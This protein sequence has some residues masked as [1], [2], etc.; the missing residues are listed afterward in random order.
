[1]T[2]TSG[3][4]L[5]TTRKNKKAIITNSKVNSA[6]YQLNLLLK[7]HVLS[8]NPTSPPQTPSIPHNSF[9]LPIN[10]PNSHL[11]P[12]QIPKLPDLL[13]KPQLL[14]DL[15]LHSL[16]PKLLNNLQRPN[17]I[18]DPREYRGGHG[19]FAEDAG[20]LVEFPGAFVVELVLFA[21]V[22]LG[23]VAG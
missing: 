17:R 22:D 18:L 16:H 12:K 21:L 13:P 3:I 1:M 2:K 11:P 19:D 6:S 14:H 7:Q 5:T 9:R 4:V 8:I 10:G 20:A 15:I 23:Y